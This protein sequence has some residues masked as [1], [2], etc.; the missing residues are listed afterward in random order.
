MP[1]LAPKI[2]AFVQSTSPDIVGNRI[3]ILPDGTPFSYDEPYDEILAPVPEA[4][5]FIRVDLT[6]LPQAQG[7]DG[8]YDVFVTG[9]DKNQPIRNESD[10]FEVADATFDFSAPLPPTEGRIE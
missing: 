10:P 5:G 4:D 2:L 3:R 8:V 9:I 7:L 6:T 1:F